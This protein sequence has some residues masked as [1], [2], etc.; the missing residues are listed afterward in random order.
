MAEERA[1]NAAPHTH[2]PVLALRYAYRDASWDNPWVVIY[3]DTRVRVCNGLR[4]PSVRRVRRVTKIAIRRHDRGSVAAGEQ[5]RRL[6][7]AR[8]AATAVRSDW[9]GR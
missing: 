5:E 6:A 4:T 1:V 7:E 8:R 2:D 3:G 9:A